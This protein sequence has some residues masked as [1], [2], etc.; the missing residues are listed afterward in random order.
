MSNTP[1]D[2]KALYLRLLR[3]VWPYRWVF[4]ISVLALVVGAATDTSFAAL[5]KWMV[6]GTFVDKDPSVMKWLPIAIIA[7][8]L[9]RVAA[10]FAGHFSINWVGNRVVM[11]LRKLMFER[12]MQLPLGYFSEIGRASCRE[13]VWR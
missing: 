10:S 8:T 6:D 3:H 9:V 12:L 11:D 1:L 5:M 4:L 2:T 7:I 13:R